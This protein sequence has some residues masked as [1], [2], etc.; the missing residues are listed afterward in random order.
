M[1]SWL[2]SL[3][4]FSHPRVITMLFFGFSAGIPLLLIFSSLGLWLREAGVDRSTATLFSWAALGYS[5]KFVWAPLIDC[6]PLPFLSKYLGRRRAWILLAQCMIMAAIVLMAMTD[7]AAGHRALTLMAL[8]AVLLGFS[9]ATQDI[10]IDAYRIESAP[11]E[12]QA[13]LSST[14]IVGYRLAMIVSGAGSLF[15]ASYFGSTSEAYLYS[16]WQ[17][18]YLCMSIIMLVGVATTLIIEEPEINQ[19]KQYPYDQTVYLRLFAVF[20][21]CTITFICIFSASDGYISTLKELMS[22]LLSTTVLANFL[23][24]TARLFISILVAIA[25]AKCCISLR[26]VE[27]TIIEESYLA[28]VKEFFTRYTLQVAILLLVLVGLYRISDIVLGVIAN[29]FYQDMGYSKNEIAGI[30]K[31]FGLIM[32]LIGGLLGGLLSLRVGVMK[33]LFLGAFLTVIT[34]LLFMVLAEVGYNISLLYLVISSDNLAAGIASA[35]FIAFLS[36]L[37]NVSFTAMQ[38][39]IFSSL[40]TL[41]P[42]LIGGYSGAIVDQIG[43]TQF[44]LVA[45]LLGIPVLIIIWL[46]NQHLQFDK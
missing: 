26:V 42:K 13:L 16:A 21:L 9:S 33:T 17:T 40:M 20:I 5:F 6:I 31:T 23:G 22:S 24:E 7:P 29:I 37:T 38:Y 35:A 45:S 8:G 10:V 3:K 18:T 19:S 15:I 4:T 41:F 28:P 39:A 1:T 14:Y 25:V 30:V 43:Y 44:F 11:G 46:A 36:K 27:D 32:T 34:N 12:M 2:D